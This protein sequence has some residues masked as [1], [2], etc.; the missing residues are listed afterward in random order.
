MDG[1]TKGE[2]TKARV[3][4]TASRLI[5]EKG[6]CNTSIN[7]IIQATGVKKGNLYFYFPSKEDLSLAILEEA[8]KQFMAFLSRSLQGERPLDKLSNFLDVVFEKHRRE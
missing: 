4:E 8:N 5:N 7:D 2:K 3:L 1:N 6:F